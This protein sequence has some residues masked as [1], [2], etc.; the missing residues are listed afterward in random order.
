MTGRGKSITPSTIR[1]EGANTGTATTLSH[2][3]NIVVLDGDSDGETV[4]VT[5]GV[6]D[7]VRVEDVVLE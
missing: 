6:F 3:G 7:T 5:E 2:V 1:S 4:R